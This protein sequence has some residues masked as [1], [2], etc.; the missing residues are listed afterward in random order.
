MH[1]GMRTRG[2]PA[3]RDLLIRPFAEGGIVGQP[4]W[5]ERRQQQE[6]QRSHVHEPAFVEQVQKLRKIE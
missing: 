5:H 6:I 2:G 1:M 4:E 3:R